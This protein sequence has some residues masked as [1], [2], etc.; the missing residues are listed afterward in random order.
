[1]VLEATA[2]AGGPFAPFHRFYLRHLIPLAGRLSP[3]PSAYAYLGRSI[4]E[5]GSGD[6]FEADLARAGFDGIARRDFLLGATALWTARSRGG[7][8]AGEVRRARLGE[9]ARGEM[10][11]RERRGEGEWRWWT[12]IQWVL[13]G[14]VLA[15]L[16]YAQWLFAKYG[17]DLR[18]EPWQRTGMRALLALAMV[19]FGVRTLLLG[20]RLF[21]PPPRN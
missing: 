15:S 19:G 7:A 4:L 5:F 6:E 21:G 11:N 1:V 14:A 8:K 2:P 10:P 20:L 17:H 12:G 9:L 3:E 16:I 18:L 13:S